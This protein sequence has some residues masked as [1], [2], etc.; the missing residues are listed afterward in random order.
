MFLQLHHL[1]KSFTKKQVISDLSLEVASG[2]LVC[3]LGASGCGKTTTLRMIGGF[4]KPN[5]GTILLDGQDVTTLPPEVRP[6]TTVFQSYALFPHMSVAQNVAYGLTH[7]EKSRTRALGVADKNQLL[8][9]VAD[10]LETVGL[11]EYADQRVTRLSGGQRQ[12]VALARALIVSPKL[13]LLDEPLSNLDANLR[14]KMRSELKRIQELFG[15]TMLFVTHDTEEALSLADRVA[16]MRDGRIE[17]IATPEDLYLQPKNSY[18]AHFLGP[19][20]EL[21][22]GGTTLH[23]RP[24][25]VRVCDQGPYCARVQ[26]VR[27][28]GNTLQ[29]QLELV[30][31]GGAAAS[32]QSFEA[33]LSSYQRYA[34][35]EEFPFDIVRTIQL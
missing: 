34:K 13:I 31:E 30:D 5:A 6:T 23:F 32:A 35:G 17:Q 12:R 16:L 29:Y 8:Q 7:M 9:R 10:M 1:S 22:F 24:E 18:V 27:F 11:S 33:H 3:L 28:L 2:E 25:D 19:V 15:T 20:C 4:L 14:V 26:D 21:T